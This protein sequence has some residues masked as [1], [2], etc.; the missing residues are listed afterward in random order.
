MFSLYISVVGTNSFFLFLLWPEVKGRMMRVEK[1]NGGI[2][3]AFLNMKAKRRYTA[4][5]FYRK[6]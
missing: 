3:R 4:D 5:K 2:L 1:F 6:P